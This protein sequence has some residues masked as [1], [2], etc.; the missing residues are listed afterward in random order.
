MLVAFPSIRRRDRRKFGRMDLMKQLL[1]LA[2]AAALALTLTSTATAETVT[3]PGVRVG[4]P[5]PPGWQLVDAGVSFN[6]DYVYIWVDAEGNCRWEHRQECWTGSDGRVHC[7]TER[8]YKCDRDST[9][10]KLPPSV[11]VNEEAKRANFAAD[12]GSSVPFGKIK[13]FLWSKWISLF[14]GASL[15]VTYEGASLLLDPEALG[16]S[17]RQ[18]RFMDL[19]QVEAD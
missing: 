13:R 14:D 4:F 17:D 7:R 5:T 1:S 19:Y 16:T 2:C 12:D 6:D 15:D 10:Y 8:E 11:S 18:A 3:I 9:Y